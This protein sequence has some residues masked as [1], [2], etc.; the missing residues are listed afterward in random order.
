[1]QNRLRMT[2]RTKIVA[3][4]AMLLPAL[5]SADPPRASLYWEGDYNT[6]A[7][8][9]YYN[10]SFHVSAT[11]GDLYMRSHSVHLLF[12]TNYANPGVPLVGGIARSGSAYWNYDG[13]WAIGNNGHLYQFDSILYNGSW[14]FGSWYDQGLP[15]CGNAVGTPALSGYGQVLSG[16]VRCANGSL[17]ERYISTAG[18]WTWRN[19]SHPP[20]VAIVGDPVRGVVPYDLTLAAGSDG[21]LWRVLNGAWTNLGHPYMRPVAGITLAQKSGWAAVITHDVDGLLWMASSSDGVHFSWSTLDG[22]SYCTIGGSPSATFDGAGNLFIYANCTND[23]TKMIARYYRNGIWQWS[24]LFQY[25][26]PLY[27]GIHPLSAS[28]AGPRGMTA[29]DAM[30]GQFTAMIDSNG[31]WLLVDQWG[32]PQ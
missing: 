12:T 24:P 31:N 27:G 6:Y 11:T 15:P 1:L 3:L 26:D 28:T 17:A 32:A 2:T 29:E 8:N 23:S 4:F 5:A 21:N 25:T 22:N 9:G 10:Y 30:G 16:V 14:T 19:L 20:G 7:L 18:Q 13:V